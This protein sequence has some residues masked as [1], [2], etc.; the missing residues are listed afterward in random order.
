[1]SK[2][3]SDPPV[4]LDGKLKLGVWT[5]VA[6]AGG[7]F[8]LA[9]AYYRLPSIQDLEK[10]FDRH[11]GSADSHPVMSRTSSEFKSGTVLVEARIHTLE[12]QQRGTHADIEYIRS[13]IDYLTEQTVRQ[14]AQARVATLQP[15][16]RAVRA[17]NTAVE[18]LQRGA[19]PLDAVRGSITPP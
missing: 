1:M 2:N 3:P 8:T 18:L 5:L 19:P 17:G 14:A 13:R 12:E 11:N 7:I 16:P 6:I 15:G 4:N 10:A 9:G